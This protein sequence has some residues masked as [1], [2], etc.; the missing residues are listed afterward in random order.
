MAGLLFAISILLATGGQCRGEDESPIVQTKSGP[1][2]GSVWKT[3]WHNVK[4]FSFRGVP[5]AQPPIGDLRFKPPVPIDPW[6]NVLDARKERSVCPQLSGDSYVGN[7]DCLYLNVHTPVTKF[8]DSMPKLATMVWIYGGSFIHGSGDASTY[9]PDFFMEQNVVVVTLNYRLGALGFLHLNHPNAMGNAG[10]LDQNLALKWVKDNIAAFGGDPA[11]VTIFG[12]SA[13]SSSVVLHHLSELSSDLFT[14]SISQSGT[15]LVFMYRNPSNSVRNARRLASILNFDNSNTDQLLQSYLRA[16]AEDLVR[17]TE[18]ISLIPSS[19]RDPFCSLMVPPTIDG[20]FLTECPI[21]LFMT[22]KFKKCD[23]ML[24]FTYDELIS[25][26]DSINN[27]VTNSALNN[28]MVKRIL[29]ETVGVSNLTMSSGV[30][31]TQKFFAKYSD[32]HPVYFYLLSY[33]DFPKKDLDRLPPQETGHG[34]DLALLF[35]T[36][37]LGSAPNPDD[38]FNVMRRKMVTLWANFAKYGYVTTLSF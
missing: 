20:V 22:G 25:F 13:G 6:T 21:T 12:Q 18:K 29:G 2:Q 11:N 5:Y 32:E 28:D 1:V 38:A 36:D 24:G 17:G 26:S 15:P 9:G 3:P 34:D 23:K 37:I 10:L 14:R 8:D 4:Y 33:A 19:V 31:F 7:E 35:N 27:E 30:D 16:N